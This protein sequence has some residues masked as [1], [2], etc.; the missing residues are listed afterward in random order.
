MMTSSCGKRDVVRSNDLGVHVFVVKHVGFQ[1]YFEAIQDL[2]NFW[3]ILNE[4]P[5]FGWWT[6]G[7]A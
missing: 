2:G 6:R 4:Q 1:E 7:R 3:T 5:P